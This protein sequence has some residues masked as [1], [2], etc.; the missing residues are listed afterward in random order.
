M[1]NQTQQILRSI[2][3]VPVIKMDTPDH[4]APLA[5]A[6]RR[7]GLPAAEITFRSEAAVDSIRAIAKKEPEMFL[8][9][10]TILTPKQAQQAVEA[11]ARAIISPGTNLDTVRWCVQ[12][13]IP[14]IP[15]CASPTEVEVCLR[16]GLSTVK[17]FPAE[18]LG[19]V[20]M[21]KAMAGPYAEV[22][23][24]PTGGIG[25]VNAGDYLALPNVLCCGGS[26]MVPGNLLAAGRFDE[27]ET[28]ARE[29]AALRDRVRPQA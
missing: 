10:G 13:N 24:M 17:L 20:A 23:F 6:L 19:G 12:N 4:A 11:G 5:A 2:G 15:G 26:W 1:V 14:V 18:V 9:A 22:N 21:L 16:E 25:L 28:L 7:G 27:I 8:C 3:I 29:A